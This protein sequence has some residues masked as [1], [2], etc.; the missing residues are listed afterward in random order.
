MNNNT[1][2]ET[3][4]WAESDARRV[5]ANERVDEEP[6]L[7]AVEPTGTWAI[8][9]VLELAENDVMI[10]VDKLVWRAAGVATQIVRAL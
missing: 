9:E 6:L 7:V 4:R 10:P 3:Y 5:F 1:A 8:V 2:P